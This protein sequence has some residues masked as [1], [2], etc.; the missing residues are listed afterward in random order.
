MALGIGLGYEISSLK[1]ITIKLICVDVPVLILVWS[2]VKYR[3]PVRTLALLIGRYPSVKEFMKWACIGMILN[4]RTFITS[5]MHGTYYES[6]EYVA[7]ILIA[8]FSSSLIY[9]IAEEVLFR[10]FCYTALRKYGKWC[11][12]VIS[13]LLFLL[14]HVP[15]NDAI[16]GVFPLSMFHVAFFVAISAI[17]THIYESSGSLLLCITFHGAAN[18][19]DGAGQFVRY[20]SSQL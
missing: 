10:G 12:F 14:A 11:A 6:L 19:M 7:F 13:T 20:L 4:A 8:T 5:A 9:P 1:S 15:L 16:S 2:F 3:G 18:F 17:A